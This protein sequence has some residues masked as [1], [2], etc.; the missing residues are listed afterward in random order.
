MAGSNVERAHV[1]AA[2]IETSFRDTVIH[3][4]QTPEREPVAGGGVP[5]LVYSNTGATIP[6]RPGA[7]R[8]IADDLFT[9][10]T[11][12]CNLD[13]FEFTIIGGGTGTG[14]GFTVSYALYNDCPSLGG[15]IIPGT[16]G[17]E[18]FPDDG[19]EHTIMVAPVGD[20]VGIPWVVWL[21]VAFDSDTAGWLVG[22][23]PEIGFSADLFDFP[24]FPCEATTGIPSQY[25]A[26]AA[27]IFCD[28][29]APPAVDNPNPSDI[30]TNVLTNAVLSWN[31]GVPRA[32][33][34]ATL[35]EQADVV[36][37]ADFRC[38]TEHPEVVFERFQAAVAAGEVPDPARM[39][40]PDVAPRSS[41]G[42]HARGGGAPPV[43]PS[44]IF[45]FEDSNSLLLT[46][47][48]SSALFTLMAEA[49]NA[50]L[51]EHGDN[52][53]YVAFFMNF[54]PQHQ[55]NS[56]AFHLGLENTVSGIGLNLFNNRPSFGVTGDNVGGWVMMWNQASWSTSLISFT[57]LVLGQEFEHRFAMFLSG[58]SGGRRLQGGEVVNDPCGRGAHWNF[59]VDGQGSGMEIAEWVGS[60]PTRSGGTLS[61]N[62]DIGGVFSYPDLYLMGYVNGADMDAGASELRYMDDS[63]TCG[64]PYFGD[65]STWGSSDIIAANG[66]R[67]PDAFLAQKHYNTAWVMFHLPGDAPLPTST[68]ITRVVTILNNWSESYE[69]GTVG[70]GTMSNVLNPV[71]PPDACVTTYDV[72]LDTTSPPTTL[73]CEGTSDTMCDPG[74]LQHETT[75][76]WQVVAT[77][78]DGTTVGPIWSFTTVVDGPDCDGDGLP[79]VIEIAECT[80]DPACD[81]CNGN[82]VPDGCDI[83]DCAAE[84]E[85]QDCNGNGIPDECDGGCP[86]LG[87]FSGDGIIDLEDFAQ[88]PGCMN[89]PGAGPVGVHCEIFDFTGEGGVDLRDYAAFQIVFDGL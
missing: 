3:P 51:I 5:T 81:D 54:Q 79:D 86:V 88:F 10:K 55:L 85:C 13:R 53:D 84:P 31:G 28:P 71:D 18:S 37:P 48:S 64:S 23:P 39:Q 62:T 33:S 19:G 49:T 43:L 44:D 75:Y 2:P 17:E 61:Y 30:A 76:A 34:R 25:A 27:R 89:G 80:G 9:T 1:A 38:G 4:D 72:F 65:V 58:I 26:F 15:Q 32:T 7:F 63:T 21:S 78:A 16:A 87:D 77:D 29:A 22:T 59:R 42:S 82:S 8:P 68:A 73:I 70:L 66:V 45:L 60:P 69:T 40:L 35:E 12:G 50:V 20:P 6:L 83:T 36:N 41:F 67:S 47:F 57:Q 56:A 46:N 74:L 24:F 52:F 14:P 11:C